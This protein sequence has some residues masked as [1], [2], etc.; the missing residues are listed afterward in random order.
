M[1]LPR[2]HIPARRRT[3]VAVA[4]LVAFVAGGA[5]VFAGQR[6]DGIDEPVFA[7]IRTAA[8]PGSGDPAR[9]GSLAEERDAGVEAKVVLLS[10]AEYRP[11]E[12][13]KDLAYVRRK[14]RE[15][16]T[17]REAGFELILSLG[18]NRAPAWLHERY[19]DTRFV[20]QHGDR[21]GGKG[22]TGDL[23][24][25]FNRRLRT[26]AER[27]LAEVFR[28]FGTDF[29]AVRLGFG[30]F[31]ELSYPPAEWRGRTNSYWAFDDNAATTNPAGGWTPG[32][33]SPD[34]Q[35][36]RFLDWYLD[37]LVDFERWQM[38]AVRKHFPGTLM[39]L[40]PSW[41]VRPGRVEQAVGSDLDGTTPSEVSGE[42]PRGLDFARQVAAIDDED[43]VVATTWL[44]ADI[45]LAADRRPDKRFWSPVKYVSFLAENHPDQ[46]RVFGENGGG[47]G[48]AGMALAARQ[49]QRYG[50][51]G[52]AWFDEGELA[53]GRFATMED[54]RR[55][56]RAAEG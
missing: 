55:T 18:V 8:P 52:M 42:L 25:V 9:T 4:L 2:P 29:Y 56:I 12:E 19:E 37:A 3:L 51:M 16:R 10:W 26:V 49:M 6:E 54:L 30:R 28:D 43:V 36:D 47:D 39:V 35:A 48:A 33:P 38:A 53:S 27:Y 15:F 40:L 46:L 34:G 22:Q 14:Q 7:V 24:L 5:I 23:N 45:D 13:I 20:N 32:S 17:L 41:G 44:E 31:G 1:R 50:L 11:F 21:Y